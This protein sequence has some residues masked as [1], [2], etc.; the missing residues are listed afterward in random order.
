MN[1]KGT[2][3]IA[4]VDDIKGIFLSII[5][6]LIELALVTLLEWVKENDL[7]VNRTE[8]KYVIQTQNFLENSYAKSHTKSYVCFL[9]KVQR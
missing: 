9:G 3:A 2:K 7:A 1:E 5:S 6:E 4:Y 8:A